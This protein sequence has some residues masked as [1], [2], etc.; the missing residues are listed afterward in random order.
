MGNQIHSILFVDDDPKILQ[1]LKRSVEEYSDHW[2]TDF[3]S[4]AK[5]A[6]QKLSN[7]PFDAI[8]ADIQMPMMDG[9]QL[10]DLVSRTYPGVM[11]FVLSGN[12][13]DTQAMRST[14]VV[15][16]MIAKP[17]DID[18]I[19]VI[20]ERACRL[21]DLVA[22]PELKKL[23][24][25]IKRLPSVPVLY[26]QLIKELDSPNA[27]TQI[28]GNIIA[29]DTAM[30]AKILQLVN[31]A[32]FCLSENI[33]S[34]QRAVSILGFNTVKALVLGICIFSE[35]QEYGINP[36]GINS[37]WKHSLLVSSVA[38]TL[39]QKL[40]M[41]IQDQENARISGILHDIGKLALLSFPE[42]M[43]QIYTNGRGE[44]SL[45]E[46]YRMLKT[47]HAEI[48]GYLLA[49]WGIPT[50]IVDSVTF[51]H[52]PYSIVREDPDLL[53]VMYVANGLAN[54]VKNEIEINYSSYLDMSY[55]KRNGLVN[56]LDEWTEVAKSI[57]ISS[58]EN[59][60]S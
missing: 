59:K 7:E 16:Q 9:I 18:H 8:I 22:N 43:N 35:Y 5:E 50:P 17:S 27:S 10:L 31:S 19:F 48:G 45:E 54:M 25:E 60:E 33:N 49:M 46:E 13:T 3:A 2:R 57:Y 37:I 4:T 34:P 14:S 23:I 44:I 41:S 12:V 32:F 39:A 53:S 40:N 38:Y 42:F 51:H 1:G 21:R 20:V 6:L 28:I 30:T 55:L 11:R 47:S 24:T 52:R 36:V 26:N 29:K 56:Y 58:T 15:H